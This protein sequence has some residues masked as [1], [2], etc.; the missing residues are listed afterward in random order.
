MASED[1]DWITPTQAANA[2]GLSYRRVLQLID[3]GRLAS[4]RTPLGRL[5]SRESVK[6]LVEARAHG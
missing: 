4:T 2:L 5:I 6:Q 1:T 3:S